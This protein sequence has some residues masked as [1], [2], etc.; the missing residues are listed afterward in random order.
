MRIRGLVF[1]GPGRAPQVESLDLADPEPGEVLVRY[2]ASGVCRSDLHVVD[3][4]WA[5]PTPIVLG[6]EGAGVV[7]QVGDGVRHVAVGDEVV[8]SW[9]APCGICPACSRGRSWLCSGSPAGTHLQADG[10]SRVRRPDGSPVHQY[11]SIGTMSDAAVV[12][13]PA[14]VAIPA[15]VPGEVAALIGCGVSTGYGAVV[16]T[17][18]VEPGER[19][20]VVGC[21]GVGLAAVMA[22]VRC[23]AGEV[24][25]VDRVPAKLDVA[26][27]LGA[28]RVVLADDVTAG[29][30]ADFDVALD[31]I[32]SPAVVADLLGRLVPGGR[33]VLVGMTAQGVAH[34]VDGYVVPDRGLSVLGCCYGSTVAAVDFPAIAA[35]YLAGELPLDVLVERRIALDEVGTAL[36]AMRRDEGL[37]AVVDL[38]R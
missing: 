35:A 38:R 11:L 6:H 7:E 18:A 32:G 29:L 25:A 10:T 16:R 27:S 22:A 9:L 8:L 3:G 36:A 26:R 4:D 34:Q 14:V 5:R 23:G 17:A 13:G 12:P 31:C 28:T 24:V 30:G 20:V 1:D 2:A 33:V 19:V 15:G 21:G 37:R